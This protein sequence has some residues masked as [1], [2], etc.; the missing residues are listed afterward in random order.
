MRNTL[1][2]M[3]TSTHSDMREHFVIDPLIGKRQQL[4]LATQLCRMV[5]KVRCISSA[6]LDPHGAMAPVVP[7][8]LYSSV[9]APATKLSQASQGRIWTLNDSLTLSPTIC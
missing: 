2:D 7:N 5:L 1:G 8:G 3:L 4:L 9:V 6:L